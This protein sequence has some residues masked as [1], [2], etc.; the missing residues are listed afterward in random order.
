ME[1]VFVVMN[2]NVSIFCVNTLRTIFG[3]TFGLLQILQ[4]FS[5]FAS[6]LSE[7]GNAPT[8]HPTPGHIE[9]M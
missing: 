7:S 4:P 2:K 5:L 8:K 6:P 1:G 9:D 3:Q